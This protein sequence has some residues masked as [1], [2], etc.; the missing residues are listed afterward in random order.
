MGPAYRIITPHLVIRCYN[1]I[2]APL[3]AQSI[4]ESLDHL[5]PWMP[6]AAV[7]PE[8]LN[9]KVERMRLMRSNFDMGNEFVFG[10][11]NL[12]QNRLLGGTGLH[13]RVGSDA[14][15]IGYW[16]HKDFTNHG[17]ATET[18]AA[19]T[20]VAFEIL[21]VGRLE[22]H[23]SV[24]NSRSAAIPVKLGY[25]H[26]ATLRKRSFAHGRL[27]DQMIW[28]LFAEDYPSTISSKQEISAF[29]AAERRIL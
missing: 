14:L 21:G 5:L 25:T 4:T 10:I 7:E 19:L 26:E 13:P 3:L 20:K 2:D 18:A 24:E 11:F 27:T 17:Y 1:P 22:I 9:A 28:S 6:W 23:C 8:H 29:D 16:I 15:E 12:E